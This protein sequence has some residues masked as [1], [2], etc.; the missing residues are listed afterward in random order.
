[1]VEVNDKGAVKVTDS[2]VLFEKVTLGTGGTGEVF[3]GEMDSP[4]FGLIPV[5][6]KRMRMKAKDTEMGD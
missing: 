1:M 6:I 2:L 4:E 5:A 3:K